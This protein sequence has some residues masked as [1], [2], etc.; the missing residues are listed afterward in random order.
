MLAGHQR[1]WASQL[2][3]GVWISRLFVLPPK[4]IVLMFLVTVDTL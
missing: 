1:D 3:V 4:G 2:C